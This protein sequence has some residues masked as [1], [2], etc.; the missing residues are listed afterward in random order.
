LT[1][2]GVTLAAGTG[3]SFAYEGFCKDGLRPVATGHSKRALMTKSVQ[4]SLS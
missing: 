3:Q 1:N 2:C 4:S